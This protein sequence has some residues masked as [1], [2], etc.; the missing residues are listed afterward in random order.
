[1]ISSR[2]SFSEADFRKSSYSDPQQN[3][4]TVARRA[5]LV[6]VRDSKT[7]FDSPTDGRLAFTAEQFADFLSS[8]RR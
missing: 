3:C 7:V 2:P 8:I 6:A 4:V 1:M 5:D